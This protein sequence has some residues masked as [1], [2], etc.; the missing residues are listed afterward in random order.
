MQSGAANLLCTI[1]KGDV[2]QKDAVCSY[3]KAIQKQQTVLV[4]FILVPESTG[5]H[6]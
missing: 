1:F 5:I 6:K 3:V 4:A 2:L